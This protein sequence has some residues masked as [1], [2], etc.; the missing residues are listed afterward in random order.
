MHAVSTSL[1]AL[2]LLAAALKVPEL[3]ELFLKKKVAS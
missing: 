1:L 2:I 3:L